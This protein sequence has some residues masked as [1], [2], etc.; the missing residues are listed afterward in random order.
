M[1]KIRR[2]IVAVGL[3]AVCVAASRP[4]TTKPVKISYASGKRIATLADK[5]INE[6]SGLACGMV[7]K[8]VFWTHN[9]SGDKARIYAFNTAGE[10][11]ATCRIKGAKAIDW[12]D[13]CSFE[14]DGRGV[15]LIGDT[16]D[17]KKKRS[18]CTIYAVNE[19]QLN[20]SH[21]YIRRQ[22]PIWRKIRFRYQSGP[23]DCESIA[24]DQATK[25]IYII[26]KNLDGPCE[27]YPLPWPK[28][29]A[30][31]DDDPIVLKPIAT[32]D[33]PATTAMDIS[34][35]GKRAIVLTYWPS[36][37]E[38]TRTAGKTWAQAF[39]SKPR[40]LAMPFRR[41][42]ESM[43]Y[44]PDGKTIYLTSEKLPTPLFKVPVTM[45]KN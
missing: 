36:A 41:Q 25:T 17:N 11:L 2:I 30:K 42:G 37:Y 14:I 28:K 6:S 18:N 33:I 43:C 23:R 5:S 26:T 40:I 4:A 32:L 20:P 39:G 8:N 38:Y 3:V 1:L 44:G 34:P 27:V 21:R 13:M 35:D 24:F 12:E 45:E 10:H 19:P 22:L 31:K 15:L 7:N 29:P 9:D 16:G